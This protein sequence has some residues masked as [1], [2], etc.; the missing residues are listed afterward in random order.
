MRVYVSSFAPVSLD[1]IH[2]QCQSTVSPAAW[3]SL[4][5]G[6]SDLVAPLTARSALYGKVVV[7]V[8]LCLG[9]KQ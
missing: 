1:W 4:G 9:E 3:C 2:H 5:V 6:Q 7:V 8:S